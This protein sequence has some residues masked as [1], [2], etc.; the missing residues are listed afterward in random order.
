MK[1]KEDL[2]TDS[3]YFS[4]NSSVMDVPP[5]RS[6]PS[7]ETSSQLVPARLS[8]FWP[9]PRKVTIIAMMHKMDMNKILGW[10]NFFLFISGL[11]SFMVPFFAFTPLVSI[12]MDKG[13]ETEW[14]GEPNLFC[15]LEAFKDHQH[16]IDL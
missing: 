3:R 1:K 7:R 9:H 5:I 14:L 6:F 13:S 4:V 2:K 10:V 16:R 12:K 11:P 15:Q 8:G